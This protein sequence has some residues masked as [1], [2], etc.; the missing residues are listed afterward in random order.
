MSLADALVAQSLGEA[1]GATHVSN[2][3]SLRPRTLCTDVSQL[4]PPALPPPQGSRRR[5]PLSL[6]ACF[7][8]KE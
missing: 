6:D 2:R 7:L 1:S 8:S 5:T 4:V 3:M